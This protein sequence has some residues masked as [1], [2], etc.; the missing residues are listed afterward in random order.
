[1]IQKIIVA[2]LV[3]VAML[4]AMVA[5]DEDKRVHFEKHGGEERYDKGGRDNIVFDHLSIL[6]LY[7]Y[8]AKENQ[9]LP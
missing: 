8:N 9:A 1:M 5:A 3:T 2:V 6:G 4:V 7:C